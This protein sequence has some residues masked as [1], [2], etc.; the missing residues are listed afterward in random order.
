MNDW[1]RLLRE[2]CA[3]IRSETPFLFAPH[4]SIGC[5]GCARAAFWPENLAELLLLVDVFRREEL[6]FVVL[7]NM[8][9]VLPSDGMFEGAV[10]F[11]D[12]L[13]SVGIGKS[14]FAMAGVRAKALLDSCERHGR[15]GAEFLAGI[16]CS[17][18]GAAFMNAGA[19]GRYFS[20]ILESVLVYKDGR[21]RV[22]LKEECGYGYK[23]SVFM[24]DSSVILG[25]SL[26]LDEA[27][28]Q[29]VARK[30]AEFLAARRKLPKGRSMGCVFKN[31]PDVP[32]GKLID[33]AG[34]K[35][36][37]VGGAVISP[38]HANFII[39]E[40]GATSADV[41]ALINLIKNAVFAQYG[42]GLEEEI[43]YL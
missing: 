40:G 12:G 41:K 34:L 4:C 16:P 5:G 21:I 10:I 35:G 38:Q 31:P 7:G 37:R 14:V 11:T 25:A 6:K 17:V 36:L 20:D 8:T 24:D 23:H 19:G 27:D 26:L 1:T 2:D 22:L 33:G 18:G 42:V 9:N 43:R 28:G 32:A 39:N 3:G 15:T 13:R 30:R 29:T